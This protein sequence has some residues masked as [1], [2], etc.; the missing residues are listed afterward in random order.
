MISFDKLVVLSEASKGYIASREK[1]VEETSLLENVS[2]ENPFPNLS[3]NESMSLLT[4]TILE[5]QIELYRSEGQT[6]EALVEAAV[7]AI[8]TKTEA[9]YVPIYESA[10]EKLKEIANH[11]WE[12]MKKAAMAIV[13][14]IKDRYLM[15]KGTTEQLLSRQNI[16][17]YKSYQG[18]FDVTVRAG[19]FDDANKYFKNTGT[20]ESIDELFSDAISGTE[21][22]GSTPASGLLDFFLSKENAEKIKEAGA[23]VKPSDIEGYTAALLLADSAGVDLTQVNWE[24]NLRQ[25]IFGEEKTF[26]FN[27]DLHFNQIEAIIKDQKELASIQKTYDGVVRQLQKTE[28]DFTKAVESV[29]EADDS[30]VQAAEAGEK[31]AASNSDM[32][33][34]LNV[35]MRWY[36]GVIN[37][38]NKVN[39][40][41]VAYINE[42]YAASAKILRG[43]LKGQ[44]KEASAA[45]KAEKA[46]AKEAA[47]AEKA[48][49]KETKE[50]VSAQV[51]DALKNQG[52]SE[53]PEA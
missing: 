40:L 21:Y 50:K 14:W 27:K 37:A 29:K 25:A 18:N 28:L 24:L 35:Y 13:N 52:G 45:A 41:H 17:I 31:E 32:I 4:T 19:L 5:T 9:N 6:N 47:K 12:V 7:N 11:A 3:L 36:T 49:S 10:G 44:G 20:S 42:R 30:D 8:S 26:T 43:I 23:K 53:E 1:P 46:N 34:C 51:D 16:D 48:A 33:D 2:Y 15:I 38:V 39:K 22:F